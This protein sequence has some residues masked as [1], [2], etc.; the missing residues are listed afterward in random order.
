MADL[1]HANIVQLYDFDVAAD[2]T[3][4][5]VME[6]VHGRSLGDRLRS[7][8]SLR[9]Q[10]VV[11]VVS[12]IAAALAAAHA[13]GIVHRDLKPENVMLGAKEGGGDVV[14]VI[15]FGISV[16]LGG[17]HV[18][19][20]A[21]IVG[22][23]QFMSPEQAYGRH[24]E[25]DHR[26]DQFSLAAMTYNLLTGVEPFRGSSAVAVLYQ[27]V[28][29]PADSL[30]DHV[31]WPSRRTDQV[32]RKAMSKQIEDRYSDILAFARALEQALGADLNPRTDSGSISVDPQTFFRADPAPL[33]IWASRSPHFLRA[34]ASV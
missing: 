1:D 10:W 13:R 12:Q 6:F 22:T 11:G 8:E 14:K 31:A 29:E 9:P 24:D 2:G 25:V 16:V 17:H 23:P 7:R 30:S 33:T 34:N 20:D 26:S 32:L 5:L 27:V 4:Y 19:E 15:D 21:A 28:H 3:P 18:T